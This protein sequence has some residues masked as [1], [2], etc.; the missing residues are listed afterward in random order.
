MQNKNRFKGIAKWLID[1]SLKAMVILGLGLGAFYVYGQITF[2]GVDPYTVTGVVGQFL[3]V[4]AEG[5]DDAVTDY[6]TLN[7]KCRTGDVVNELTGLTTN[8]AGAHVCNTMEIIN[9]YNFNSSAIN[10][11]DGTGLI[12]NGPPG[13]TVFANDCNGWSVRTSTYLGSPAFASVWSF[14]DK[15]GSLATCDSVFN[16]ATVKIACCQ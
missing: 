9:S 15:N 1:A 4:T 16:N 12:N 3:G 7:N 5:Y 10:V 13:F 8:N 11:A 14:T 6:A 2:P